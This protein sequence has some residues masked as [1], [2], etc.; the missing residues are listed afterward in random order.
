M[1]QGFLRP[2]W[3][4]VNL[5][6]FKTNLK[7]VARLAPNSGVLPVVKANAY[8]IGVI[9][10]I[11]AALSLS[12]VKGFAVATADEAV[13]V[14]EAGIDSMLLVLGPVTPEAIPELVKRGVSL[15]ATGPAVI[16][17]AQAAAS[18][19]GMK[20]KM[21][22]K[23]ETG[24]GRVGI[25]PGAELH[26][27]LD[28]VKSSPYLD[29]EGVFTHFA[30]ADA[31]RDYTSRQMAAFDNAIAQIYA[32]GIRPTYRHASNSAAIIDFPCSHLD[33]VRPGIMLYGS[34][35]DEALAA[36]AALEPVLSIFSRVSHV[37]RVPAGYSVGYG[38]TY[39]TSKDTTIATIPVG[40]ADGYPRLCSNRGAMLIHGKKFQVAGRVCMDQTMLDVGDE[41]VKVGDKV[42]LIGRDG[43]AVVTVDEVATLSQTIAHE[44]LTGLTARLPR[45]YV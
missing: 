16:T 17:S 26:A 10:A 44:V 42:T 3:A 31:D 29:V 37:K 32:V 18:T 22:L 28:L 19:C 6:N 2:T 20:A 27:V 21:H 38:R 4:E 13:E 40:Y 34:C 8:G 45:I 35:A 39:V 15:A 24:M 36:K 30:V 14:R 11:R 25:S 23:I 12:F 43:T 5:E 7:T 41:P 33:L 9:P 1:R